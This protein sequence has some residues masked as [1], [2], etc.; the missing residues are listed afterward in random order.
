MMTGVGAE[1][2][3]PFYEEDIIYTRGRRKKCGVVLRSYET[4]DSFDGDSSD[5]SCDLQLG[6]VK[7]AFYPSG[8]ESLLNQSKVSSSIC[9]VFSHHMH[10]LVSLMSRGKIILLTKPLAFSYVCGRDR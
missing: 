10:I 5:S 1:G 4:F 3:V 7:V 8:K 2:S 9:I 6:E